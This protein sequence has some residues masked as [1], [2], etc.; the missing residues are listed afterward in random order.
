MARPPRPKPP[1]AI[2]GYRRL[3]R[4][5]RVAAPDA[6]VLVATA[7]VAPRSRRIRPARI[8]G[9][10]RLAGFVAVL[11]IIVGTSVGLASAGTRGGDERAA[12]RP[13]PAAV[14][15]V[16][17][18]EGRP[19]AKPKPEPGATATRENAAPAKAP[20]ASE[21]AGVAVAGV[22]DVPAAAAAPAPR[23]RALP[24]TGALEVQRVLLAGASLVLLGMLVQIGGQPLPA[25]PRVSA[26]RDRARVSPRA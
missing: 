1:S 25:R 19:E 23:A 2:D 20:A 15:T 26:P 10:L 7:A 11:A 6:G 9:A 21:D 5:R 22:S 12:T 24:F 4:T 13:T 16:V 3:E 8:A 17:A 14:H 18:R